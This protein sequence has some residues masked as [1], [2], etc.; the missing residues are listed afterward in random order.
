MSVTMAKTFLLLMQFRPLRHAT[1]RRIRM[2]CSVYQPTEKVDHHG[3]TYHL[4][5]FVVPCRETTVPM[6]AR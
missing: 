6:L 4:D 2:V 1:L 5:P 3:A